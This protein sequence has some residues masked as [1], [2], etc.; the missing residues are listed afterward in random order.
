[1]E[2]GVGHMAFYAGPHTQ[3]ILDNLE[4]EIDDCV[5]RAQMRSQSA[6][7]MIPGR[8]FEIVVTTWQGQRILDRQSEEGIA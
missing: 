2:N 7:C 4:S 6:V 5:N 8:F 1:M 3:G